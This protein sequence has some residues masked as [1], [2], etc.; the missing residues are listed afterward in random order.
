MEPD[1]VGLRCDSTSC[2]QF[3]FL[4]IKCHCNKVFCRDHI[5]PD[6]HSCTLLD[7]PAEGQSSVPSVKRQRCALGDCQ[8]PSLQSATTSSNETNAPST[9]ACPKCSLS[10]CVEYVSSTLSPRTKLNCSV[11]GTQ[12][13]IRVPVYRSRSRSSIRRSMPKTSLRGISQIHLPILL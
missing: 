7:G 3:D 10:F 8:K 6:K 4:P 1:A 9:A 11:I 2:N 12:I 5:S 13:R